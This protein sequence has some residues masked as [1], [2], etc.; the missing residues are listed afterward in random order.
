MG[1]PILAYKAT[2]KVD[3]QLCWVSY[4][5]SA[6]SAKLLVVRAQVFREPEASE[7][8]GR[9]LCTPFIQQQAPK[10]WP[11]RMLGLRKAQRLL[12]LRKQPQKPQ[13]ETPF[14]E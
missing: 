1:W 4:R 14:S 5:R 7:I 8:L 9:T 2:R 3:G 11:I 13:K 12:Q 10:Q 6:D